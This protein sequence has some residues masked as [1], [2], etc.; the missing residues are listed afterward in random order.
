M[1]HSLLKSFLGTNQLFQS[2]SGFNLALTTYEHDASF[3]DWHSHEE[4]SLGLLVNGTY[5][6]ELLRR[7]HKRQPGA[8]KFVPAGELHR[9]VGY[10]GQ[11]RQFNLQVSSGLVSEMGLTE[12]R[13]HHLASES[14]GMD[15]K[16]ALLKLYHEL[17]S[18]DYSPASL[19]LL[20]YELFAS[21]LPVRLPKKPPTWIIALKELLHDQ[22]N[23]PFDLQDIAGTL[24]VHPVT[25]SRYFPHYFFC[26]LSTYVRKIKVDKSL[27]L[28]KTTALSLTEIAYTCG[29]ADQS[30]FT[31]SFQATTGFLPKEFKKA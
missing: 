26:T 2:V 29:F 19:E 8:I 27:V 20:G 18:P 6:E 7:H 5:E 4:L 12:A 14:D 13:L 21:K 10:A 9:C 28:L 1:P 23:T 24:G 3:E 16:F 15:T 17:V 11:A 22:W 30:H 25:V 31:R